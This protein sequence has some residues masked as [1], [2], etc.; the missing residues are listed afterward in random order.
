MDEIRKNNE[1]GLV[2]SVRLD[3]TRIL[4][5]FPMV[6]KRKINIE[7]YRL[8]PAERLFQAAMVLASD[9]VISFSSSNKMNVNRREKEFF[10]DLKI[11]KK[12]CLPFWK[13]IS[14]YLNN[15]ER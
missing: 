14:I 4:T 1:H 15:K 8:I 10:N 2:R 9:E 11:T 12:I 5:T 6:P 13:L 7:K 3:K